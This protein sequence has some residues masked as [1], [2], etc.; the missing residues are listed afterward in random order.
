MMLEQLMDLIWPRLTGHKEVVEVHNLD[1]G[2]LD[3][4]TLTAIES[5]VAD[6]LKAVDER[7]KIVETKLAALITQISVLSAATIAGLSVLLN[8]G[9]SRFPDVPFAVILAISTYITMQAMCCLL[10]VVRGLERRDFRQVSQDDLRPRPEEK[11]IQ[12]RTRLLSTRWGT[13][14]WNDA[15]TND[16]VSHLAVAHA[17]LRNALVAIALLIAAAIVFAAWRQWVQ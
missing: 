5:A 10:A 13:V 1:L 4:A 15:T 6:R 11:A 17:A 9:L 2:E 3:E 14:W 8:T 12:Y 7:F 16:K